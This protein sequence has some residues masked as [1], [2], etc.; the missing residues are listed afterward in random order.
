MPGAASAFSTF[1][2]RMFAA[3]HF[4]RRIAPNKIPGGATS[5]VNFARPVTFAGASA[6][7]L[8]LPR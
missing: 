6:R 5:V 1:T 4:E 8:G 7:G 2:E 3:G